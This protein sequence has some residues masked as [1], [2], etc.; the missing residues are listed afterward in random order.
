M[1]NL[2]LTNQ[3][4]RSELK[5][6]LLG[7]PAQ[8][9]EGA[10]A[11]SNETDNNNAQVAVTVLNTAL[12]INQNN[13]SFAARVGEA[14]EGYY[15]L[16]GLAYAAVAIST[17]YYALEPEELAP[18]GFSLAALSPFAMLVLPAVTAFLP[19]SIRT[20]SRRVREEDTSSP[21]NN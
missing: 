19:E 8:E 1:S 4:S 15:V 20:C 9:A 12:V 5:R 2:E 3:P 18:I 14:H 11:S 21:G 6:P 16:S 10:A 13:E 17:I 7:A